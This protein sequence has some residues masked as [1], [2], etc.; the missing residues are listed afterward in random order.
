MISVITPTIRKELLPIVEKCLARQTNQ[1]YEWLVCS[2]EDYGFGIH[3]PEPKK[4]EGDFYALNKA[5]N[6]LFRASKGELVIN[7]VDGLWFDPNLLQSLWDIYLNNPKSVVSCVGHQYVDIIHGKPETMVWRDPRVRTDQGS[8]YQVRENEMEWCIASIPRQAILDV[9]GV[10]EEYDKYAALAEKE[11]CA[12]MYKAGYTLWLNQTLE[13]RAIQHPRA[14]GS[15]KWDQ[16]YFKGVDRYWI[17]IHEIEAGRRL[18][19]DHV[20]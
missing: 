11:M 12:R 9:G 2:P 6:A 14:N 19:L 10:D 4:K 20:I 17:D 1:N 8:F 16:A 5:W 18:R 15:E 13:Y 3:V 7:I